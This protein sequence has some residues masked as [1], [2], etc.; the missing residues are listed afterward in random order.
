[1]D[2]RLLSED[3]R[4]AA[5]VATFERY[6]FPK[7]KPPLFTA[8]VSLDAPSDKAAAVGAALR[9]GADTNELDHDFH[10]CKVG[11]HARALGWFVD[12]DI[13]LDP[14]I[15]GGIGGM[16]NNL[17]AIEVMLRYGA[18]PRLKSP[19]CFGAKSPLTVVESNLSDGYQLEFYQAAWQMLDQAAEALAG[20]CRRD[21]LC[22]PMPWRG[23]RPQARTVNN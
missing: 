1:M 4:S 10:K 9:A 23:R 16:L 11:V 6:W 12:A 5:Q 18:D 14:D 13:H 2:D 7:Q 8:A 3:Q 17:P 15:N 20:E 22:S 21:G 19:A